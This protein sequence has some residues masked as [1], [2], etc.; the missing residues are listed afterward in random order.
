MVTR[1]IRP[2]SVE[3]EEV[4]SATTLDYDLLSNF[5]LVDWKRIGYKQDLKQETRNY[6]NRICQPTV[7]NICDKPEKVYKDGATSESI[8]RD[9]FINSSPLD[10]VE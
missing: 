3:E 4:S 9:L 1:K 7:V 2:Y 6:L 5:C 8:R 10:F